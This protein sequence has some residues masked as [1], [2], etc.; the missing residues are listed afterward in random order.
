MPNYHK[1]YTPQDSA[2]FLAEVG[3]VLFALAKNPKPK[4]E[5]YE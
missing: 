3:L 4:G 2:E 1:L 5:S